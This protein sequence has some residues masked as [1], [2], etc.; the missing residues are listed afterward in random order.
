VS[1]LQARVD[2]STAWVAVASAFLGV[3]DMIS[4]MICLGLWVSTTEFGQ[5]TVAIALFP[6]IDRL[7]GIGLG[8]VIVQDFGDDSDAQSTVYWVGMIAATTLT[9]VLVLAHPL[10]AAWFS[11]PIVATLL[12]AYSAKMILQHAGTVPDALM[13]RELRY[14][15]LSVVR[16]I[17]GAIELVTKLATAYAGAHGVPA[18]RVWCFAL[19]PIANSLAVTVG[20]QICTRWRPRATFRRVIARRAV[21]FTAAFSGG[22]LLYFAYTN[23]D[24]LVVYTWFGD[25]A[26]G[27]YRLAYELVLDVVRVVSMVTAEV[28]FPTFA[29]LAA[30]ARAADPARRRD[31]GA[32]SLGAQLLRFTRQNLV[33]LAPFLVFILVEADDLLALLY[34]PL[35]PE[36]T[37]AARIL[38]A[39]GAL[40]TLGFVLPPLLAGVGEPARV[41]AYNAVA[42][43]VLP[44]AFVTGAALA[45]SAGYVAVA[46]AWAFG[47]PIAFALLLAMALPR[48]QL[49][50]WS[51]GRAVSGV[52]GCALAALAFGFAA[53]Q[54]L[55]A[56]ALRVGVVA[57]VVLAS[58]ALLLARV[59]RITP[60]AIVRGFRG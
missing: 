37:T 40:R 60:R 32:S 36:A 13:R 49:S 21:R 57:A 44:L 28:A 14:Y 47:Y 2:R 52:A 5:A 23:V 46:W 30:A 41:F 10:L 18:L 8:A 50:L 31:P 20:V 7:G 25:T 39:V 1:E 29:K 59:E 3:F 22:E 24:Y 54:M 26:L 35:P 11:N 38:C 48:A 51:Y 27:A 6:L 12:V 15:E 45:P 43:V 34:P 55:G 33:V 9:A 58:Y 42:S 53:R 4:T 19:G 17:A 56:G 16:V